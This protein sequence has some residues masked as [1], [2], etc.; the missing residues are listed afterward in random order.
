MSN[1][2]ELLKKIEAKPGL[3]LGTA[4][5]TH[6][7]MFIVGY[8]FARSEMKLP[9]TEAESD[10]YKNFQ[11]WLQ[12]HLQVRTVNSWD[13]IILLQSIDEKAAFNYFFQLLET[14][15]QRDRT[16]D[17]DPILVSQTSTQPGKVA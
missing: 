6:L 10:F 9:T 1:L 5:I 8:R 17:V 3:Y 7:R 16:Q 14:F 4:S 15:Y 11:P 2:F 12:I 13:K